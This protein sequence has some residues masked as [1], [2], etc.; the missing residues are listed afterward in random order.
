VIDLFGIVDIAGIEVGVNG[1]G[2]KIKCFVG[3]WNRIVAIF[4]DIN[5]INTMPVYAQ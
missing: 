3:M 4:H 5:K 1:D 2:S